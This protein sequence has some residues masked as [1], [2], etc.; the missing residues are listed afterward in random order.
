MNRNKLF[1]LNGPGYDS[2]PFVSTPE[3]LPPVLMKPAPFRT[4][5]I[6]VRAS[7]GSE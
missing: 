4:R 7:K 3:P 1:K 2:K 6:R 5:V